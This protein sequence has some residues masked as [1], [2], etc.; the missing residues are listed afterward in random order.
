MHQKLHLV[1]PAVLRDIALGDRVNV[2]VNLVVWLFDQGTLDSGGGERV[3]VRGRV[4]EGQAGV[5][6][7]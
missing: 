6:D 3:D 5:G 4:L 1:G 7:S 2:P